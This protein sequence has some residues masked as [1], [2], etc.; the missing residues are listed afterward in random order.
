MTVA[1]SGLWISASNGTSNW[2]YTSLYF[3]YQM[4]MMT[5]APKVRTVAVTEKV[6]A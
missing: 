5:K 2:R 3:V 1:R 4:D 6:A